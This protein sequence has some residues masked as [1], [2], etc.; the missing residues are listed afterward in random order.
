MESNHNHSEHA[1]LNQEEERQ[2]EHGHQHSGHQENNKAAASSSG[3]QDHSGHMVE[4]FKKRF[5]VS[6]I[7]TIPVLI[8]SP[9]IQ[10]FFG[11]KVAFA[12]DIYLLFILSSFIFFYGG[13]PFLKGLIDELQKKMPGM[14]TLIGVAI[15]V[16]YVYS[17][18]VVFGLEGMVFFWEL[19]TL[20]DIMLLGHWIEMRSVMGAS[21]AL[22]ELA[23]LLPKNAHRLPSPDSQQVEDI[24]LEEVRAGDYLLIRPGEKVPADGVVIEGQ[25]EIDESILTGESVPVEKRV[26]DKVIGGSVNGSGSLIIEVQKT[27]QDSFIAQIVSLVREAQQNKSRTQNLADRAA[28]WLTL[29]ALSVGVL[30]FLSW[31]FGVQ[32]SLAFAIERAVTVMVIT[33]PHALGLAIPL[34]VAVSTSLAAQRGFIIRYR[35]AFENMRNVNA[36]IFDKTGTLTLGKFGVTD[37]VSLGDKDEDEILTL[38][39]SLEVLSEHPIARGITEKATMPL[40]DVNDFRAV[41]GKGVE[42]Y[43]EG[44]K[45]EVMSY[46]YV[47]EKG[48]IIKEPRIDQFLNQGKTVVFLLI[49]G[50]AK[51]AMALA[52][53]IRPE[54]KKAISELKNRGIRC[55]MLTGD[56]QKVARWVAEETGLDEFFAEVLP[57]EK[58]E[59][60]REIR[61]RGLITA[62]VG[63]GVNDSPA[64]AQADIGIAIG[65]G[66]DVTVETGDII[67]VRSNPYDIVSI[68]DLSNSTYRKMIQ[69]LFWATGYN[70]VAIPLAAGVLSAYGILLSPAVGAILMSL[71]TVIVAINAQF[72][73]GFAQSTSN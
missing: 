59:K 68:I 60:V 37:L 9:Q 71:S 54:S 63:D 14:M 10:D 66:A 33:C 26:D 39:A 7:V 11:Y 15:I 4:D 17:T 28:F 73:R 57:Q 13:Y 53:V 27:G 55:L 18:A 35:Q 52:D 69:N 42:G 19:A 65:T 70:A 41:T 40:K 16:S 29:I 32:E 30:T 64:L 1:H 21:R 44:K 20:I 3:H 12:G 6:L 61:E 34:V 43:I 47:R 22:E 50:E 25:T 36:V 49:E 24:P 46:K 56:N 45:V 31:F 67:L 23:Q 62:M 38:A 5:W 72:L 58:A 2:N 48:I 8:L 51:G